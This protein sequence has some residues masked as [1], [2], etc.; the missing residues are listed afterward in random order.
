MCCVALPFFA[1]GS[2][3]SARERDPGFINEAGLQVGWIGVFDEEAI[4]NFASLELRLAQHW[5]GIRPW[6]GV[7]VVDSGTWFAGA[8]FIYDFRLPRS[9]RVT[10]GSG[11]FYY[12]R[13]TDRDKD[14]GFDLEFYSFIEATKEFK[15]GA[16]LGLRLGHLSNAGLGRRNPGT[17]TFALVASIPLIQR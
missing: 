2:E 12:R 13:R 1:V 5:R 11:P 4:D 16:R 3:A 8:G 15:R 17:E 14:L 7:T 10:I 6:M 9:F